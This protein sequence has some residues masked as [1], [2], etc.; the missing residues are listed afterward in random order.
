MQ[1]EHESALLSTGIYTVSAAARLTG[2]SRGKIG[3]WIKGY[4]F[5][6]GELRRHSDALLAGSIGPLDAEVALGFLDLMEIRFVNAFLLAGVT[7]KTMR[8]APQLA[9][10]QIGE[11]HPFC[12]NRF[13]T[14]GRR[15]LL[16]P[17]KEN[18]DDALLVL[19]SSQA[20]FQRIL[21]PFLT[22]LD[23]TGDSVARWWPMGRER[24]IVIDPA[25]NL[26]QPSAANSGVPTEV[27]ARSVKAN[28]GI[29]TVA[30]WYEVPPGEVRDAVE[31]EELLAA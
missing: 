26:G 4:D 30:L 6:S 27:L 21:D 16:G 22:Q 20:E 25:R 19:I 29:E 8:L 11:D 14:D 13:V 24:R 7:W 10:E 1:A 5:R 12:S 2:V 9:R 3:R 31:F 18:G 28:D 23:F 17:A 15:I